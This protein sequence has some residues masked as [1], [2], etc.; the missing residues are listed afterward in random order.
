MKI[1]V[2]GKNE[3]LKQFIARYIAEQDN[4]GI[5]KN[6]TE[7][8]AIAEWLNYKKKRKKDKSFKAFFMEEYEHYSPI[9]SD[10]NDIYLYDSIGVYPDEVSLI[11]V[12]GELDKMGNP[13]ILNVRLNTT[14]GDV[15]EGFVIYNFFSRY[16]GTVNTY[17]DGMAFSIGAVI[18]AVGEKRIMAT[19]AHQ[20]IHLPETGI[21]GNVN[22][23]KK[24]LLVL[25]SIGDDI[26]KLLA[27]RAKNLSQDDMYELMAQETWYN[28]E[29]ALEVGLATHIEGEAKIAASFDVLQFRNPPKNLVSADRLLNFKNRAEKITQWMGP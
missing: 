17:V 24:E 29:Q 8:K 25:E 12:K 11:N 18:A 21:W 14:G 15:F 1:I 26:A 9:W 23:L 7:I 3:D 20:M 27:N 13:E 19:N 10:G 28:S 4:L 6:F 16:P 2:P 22:D 5:D